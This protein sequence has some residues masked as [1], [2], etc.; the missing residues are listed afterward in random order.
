MILDVIRRITRSRAPGAGYANRNDRTFCVCG[1]P[2]KSIER[3]IFQVTD[4]ENDAIYPKYYYKCPQC[5][6][7]SAVNI[8]FPKDKYDDVFPYLFIDDVKLGLA[9]SRIAWIKEKAGKDLPSAPVI[10]DLGAGEG[11]VCQA[12][13]NQFTAARVYAVEADE[14][15][16]A[17]FYRQ[18][19]GI[20]FVASFIDAFLDRPDR[21]AADLIIL[22]DV[23]EHLIWPE[24]TLERIVRA[25]APGG[26]LYMTT[27]NSR[28]FDGDPPY[29]CPVPPAQVDWA[30]A[31]KT[32]QHIFM[33]EPGLMR[34]LIEQHLDI[35]A[36]SESF[37]T[38]IRKD[39]VY[40]TIL[41]RKIR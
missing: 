36:E 23:L 1:E 15:I 32:C 16:G 19:D 34:K 20:I 4:K 24:K 8:Y 21:P 7:Y 29:P 9:S 10:F 38:E 22:T 6:S 3:C 18:N 2:R 17:K 41:G 31:N 40:S 39:S 12:L 30:H 37:E 33:I 27:P 11:A 5:E 28:T 26:L 25:L 13:A 35:V 14:R